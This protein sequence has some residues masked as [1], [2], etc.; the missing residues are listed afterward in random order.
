MGTIFCLIV[1]PITWPLAGIILSLRQ[2][3][4]FK[5]AFKYVIPRKVRER[6]DLGMKPDHIKL[7]EACLEAPF[8]LSLQI[9][10][11]LAG[12]RPGLLQ[13]ISMVASLMSIVLNSLNGNEFGKTLPFKS[14]IMFRLTVSPLFILSTL[15]RTF[16]VVIMA[17]FI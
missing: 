1:I 7:V 15:Y 5:T 9:F 10:V 11:I 17:T 14:M 3:S 2:F 8:Q 12:I 16:S 4:P 13:I 6:I